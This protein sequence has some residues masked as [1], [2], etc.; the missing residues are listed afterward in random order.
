MNEKNLENS[1]AIIHRG[2]EIKSQIKL[3]EQ[4]FE[5]LQPQI[6][7]RVRELSKGYDKYAVEV[8]DYGTF[9]IAK[10]RKWT[11]SAIVEDLE[12]KLKTRKHTEEATGEAT[13]EE[14]DTLRFNELKKNDA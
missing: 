3:L 13:A 6:I 2:A 10:Y 12:R 11:Y 4:E 5:L 8:G 9:S 1:E 7:A 14:K